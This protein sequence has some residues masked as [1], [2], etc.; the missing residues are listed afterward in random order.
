MVPV[1][2][3][4]FFFFFFFLF[5]MNIKEPGRTRYSLVRRAI[6]KGRWFRPPGRPFSRVFFPF[7]I[8]SFLGYRVVASPLV[9]LG[10]CLTNPL[11]KTLAA[12][13]NRDRVPHVLIIA[14]ASFTLFPTSCADVTFPSVALKKKK[15][16]K[17]CFELCLKRIFQNKFETTTTP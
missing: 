10:S 2:A 12:T 14:D 6:P 16:K 11:D 9:F 13:K 8:S 4:N 5:S 15:K 3:R 1:G 7:L 17:K